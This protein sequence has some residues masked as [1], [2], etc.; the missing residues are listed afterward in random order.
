MTKTQTLAT[1]DTSTAT[2]ASKGRVFTGRVVGSIVVFSIMCAVCLVWLVTLVMIPMLTTPLEFTLTG[3]VT[4]GF[5]LLITV[6]ILVAVVHNSLDL[7]TSAALRIRKPDMSKA[8][9]KRFSINERLQHVWLLVTTAVSALTGFAIMFYASWG[10]SVVNLLGG[11]ETTLDIHYASAI[12]MGILVVY[13]FGFYT[14]KYFANRALGL[15]ARLDINF[16]KKDITDFFANLKFYLGRGARPRFDKYS[17]AQRFDYWGIYWGMVILGAPGVMMW[18]L[19]PQA[20]GGLAYI[21]HVK[22]ALLAVLFLGVFHFY[23]VHYTPRQFPGDATFLTGTVSEQEMAE[24]HPLE[25][26]EVTHWW[27]W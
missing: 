24:D 15:P 7:V 4:L 9:V 11:F 18:A 14:A 21:F 5:D 23:Q 6:L 22:E 8:K 17:Y 16:S 26:K 2:T 1:G 19:G 12:L 25:P 13:H 10:S 3:I 27:W 20:F